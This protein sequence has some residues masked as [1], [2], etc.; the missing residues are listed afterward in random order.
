MKL[1]ELFLCESDDQL[2]I[3]MP[4]EEAVI[5][6]RVLS[7]VFRKYMKL[8]FDMSQHMKNRVLN[9]GEKGRKEHGEHARDKDHNRED[10]VTKEELFGLFNKILKDP[11]HRREILKRKQDGRE[12]EG[13][14]RDHDTNVNVV[15]K[16]AYQY[17]HK[18]PVFKIVTIMRNPN[19]K[20]IKDGDLI[21]DV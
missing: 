2:L 20:S 3:E 12:I 17:R 15:F 14:I 10:D 6:Q 19:F 13:V 8:T 9:P 16:V 4:Y 7:S 1:T 11:R 18:F 21:F 5:A